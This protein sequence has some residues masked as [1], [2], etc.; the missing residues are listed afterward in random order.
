MVDSVRRGWLHSTVGSVRPA[1]PLLLVQ[2]LSGAWILPLTSFL[3]I[4]LE[5][6]LH[7]TPVVIASV[8]VVGQL[9]G[10]VASLLGGRLGD[11]LGSK[12]V[13]VLGL[14]GGVVSSLVFQTHIPLLVTLL[15]ALAGAA[16]SAQTLG[17]SSYLTRMADP[18]RLGL[19]SALFSLSL[20]LGG[21]L[22]SPAAGWLLDTSG[23]R[24]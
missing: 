13:L 22:G 7:Y 10:M 23:F 16:G 3:P 24:L 19:L 17:G 2:V 11:T 14:L 9:S 18:Q 8:I 6:Q 12:W 21:A 4:Y 20:T 5:E 1:M 15:W